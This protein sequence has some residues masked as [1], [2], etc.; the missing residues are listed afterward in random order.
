M[1]KPAARVLID[2][3]G[4]SG[5]IMTGSFNVLIGGMPAARQGDGFTC[6]SHG[7]GSIIEGEKTVLINGKPA[8]R[9]GDKTSCD[10]PPDSPVQGP[11]PAKDEIKYFSIDKNADE[12]GLSP[13]E[14][15]DN[16]EVRAPQ[17]YYGTKRNHEDG[18]YDKYVAG[19]VLSEF[20]AKGEW[21][22][23]YGE[24]KGGVGG[25]GG[26][27]VLKA[28]GEGNVYTGKNGVFGS[29]IKTKGS[30]VSG[31]GEIHLGNT[32][33]LYG[34]GKA[35]GDLLYFEGNHI[36]K[37]YNTDKQTGFEW[38]E[39]AEAGVG[40]GDLSFSLDTPFISFN[41]ENYEYS[42]DGTRKSRGGNKLGGTVGGVGGTIGAGGYWAKDDYKLNGHFK[43]GGKIG[44]GL[45]V[46]LDVSFKFKPFVNAGNYVWDKT[47]DGASTIFG[48][49]FGTKKGTVLSGCSTV[50]IGPD[51]VKDEYTGSGWGHDLRQWIAGKLGIDDDI[52]NVVG[53]G[54]LSILQFDEANLTGQA[55]G[56]V[57]SDPAMIA[58]ENALVESIKGDP[59]YG[60]EAFS[61]TETAR[62][63]FGGNRAPGEMWDQLKDPLNPQYRA[64]WEVAGN[65]LTWL[66]R[67]TNVT[68][69]VNV[70]TDG[71]MTLNHSF[72]D[73]FDLRPSKGRSDAYNTA[74][75]I[76]G[77]GYHDILG[78]NDE[79]K[80][81]AEW[82]SKR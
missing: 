55:L 3:A 37:I 10:T 39:T 51:T 53:A 67:N 45:D 21:W 16:L 70:A 5:P 24:G 46:G 12:N 54:V 73:V 76:L 69:T 80:I 63:G 61:Y 60:K 56:K 27:S 66:V 79:L 59:R 22:E 50:L 9:M 7:I 34:K 41:E 2:T 48:I 62:V 31:D 57:K 13:T 25:S 40:K 52:T 49:N 17:V 26:F 29:E 4:H 11:S 81:N 30:V 38:E 33:I 42:E 23:P 15:P 6:T 68:S 74:T 47:K 14:Y 75:G 64:T 77:T 78:G 43:I 71:S 72:S 1:G 28:G 58:R 82:T 8:A 36:S 20:R 18:T 65:E 19:G 32:D 35:T 44:L